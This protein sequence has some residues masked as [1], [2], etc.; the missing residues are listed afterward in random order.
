MVARRCLDRLRAA[1]ARYR[2]AR[3]LDHAAGRDRPPGADRPERHGHD[4]RMVARLDADRVFEQSR[5]RHLRAVHDRP[6]R[7]GPA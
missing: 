4:A 7:Q 5:R 3:A 2:L 1:H 6:R